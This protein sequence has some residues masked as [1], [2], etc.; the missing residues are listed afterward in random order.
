LNQQA[1]HVQEGGACRATRVTMAVVFSD[2]AQICAKSLDGLVAYFVTI[3]QQH[4]PERVDSPELNAV[5]HVVVVT[6]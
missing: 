1:L 2:F 6:L 3:F 4:K 5:S